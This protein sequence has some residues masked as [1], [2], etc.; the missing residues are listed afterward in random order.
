MF[1]LPGHSGRQSPSSLDPLLVPPEDL[2]SQVCVP[3]YFQECEQ[4]IKELFSADPAG[5]ACVLCHPAGGAQQLQ[6][7]QEEQKGDCPKY[8][9]FHKQV[10]APSY[11]HP[12]SYCNE[13]FN[14][15]SFWTVQE[16][17]RHEDLRSRTDTLAHFIKASQSN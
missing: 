11:F 8:C 9:C 3:H 6:V 7:E 10:S 1:S 14:H 2:A 5:L 4:N 12:S 15:V 16:I 17:L 13:R